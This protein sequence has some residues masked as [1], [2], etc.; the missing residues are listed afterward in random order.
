MPQSVF[1]G[2]HGPELLVLS[3]SLVREAERVESEAM[4][5]TAD[6]PVKARH[7]DFVVKT[8]DGERYPISP[9]VFFGTYQVIGAVGARVIGRR[10]VHPR[11]A[12]EVMSDHAECEYLPKRGKVPAPKGGWFYRSDE[13]DYGYINPQAKQKAHVVVGTVD[14]LNRTDWTNRLTIAQWALSLLPPIMTAIALVAYSEGLKGRLLGSQFLLAMEGVLLIG[15][16]LG[17]WWIRRNSWT[18]KAA[19]I[20][21][22]EAATAFQ[23]APRMLGVQPSPVFPTMALWRAAQDESL[24]VQA[25]PEGLKELKESVSATYERVKLELQESHSTEAV[26]STTSWVGL[27]IILICMAYAM[28]TH[29]QFSELVAIWLPSAVG[30]IHSSALRR[31]LERRIGAGQEFLAELLFVR[32]ELNRIAPDDNVDADNAA[33][34]E[35]LTAVL[36]VLSRIGGE[37]SQT[38][39]QL[40]IAEA[41]QIPL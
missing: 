3:S 7:G 4:V 37:Y 20:S 24:T 23:C 21:G 40:A 33:A 41:V 2:D 35:S 5:E 32:K 22:I 26:A 8:S 6:G 29:S 9:S 11:R 27:V 38:Q 18:L 17:V 12:W 39:L 14:E 16:T 1:K 31:Q 15:A 34:L 25:T 30:A 19:V 28:W 36:R 13:D 10:L